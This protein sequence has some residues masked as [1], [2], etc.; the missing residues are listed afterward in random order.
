MIIFRALGALLSYPSDD[1]RRALPEIT[2]I[3]GRSTLVGAPHRE[4][5][6]ALVD[7]LASG[8]LLD[9]EENYVELFDCGRST[10]LNL[11]EHLHGESRERG[12][13]MVELKRLYE[14]AGLELG[15]GEL[16]DYLPVV[17]EYL[18]CRELSE[19]RELLAD[20][21]HIIEAIAKALLA[22]GSAYAAV[23]QAL[24]IV[25]GKKPIAAASAVA[26]RERVDDPDE[27]WPEPPAFENVPMAP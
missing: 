7:D 3:I 10:S 16:P 5:L 15:G 24:L 23:M 25:A 9:K 6:L 19:A 2:E 1:L 4:E 21:A 13:A 18:S 22:R 11:F 17:L 14:G 12:A 20:C 8:E 26:S 27:D